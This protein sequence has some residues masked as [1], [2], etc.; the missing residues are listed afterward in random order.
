MLFRPFS[1]QSVSVCVPE[2][3]SGIS[4]ENVYANAFMRI[5]TFSLG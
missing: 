3:T 2:F 1:G 4:P 5:I